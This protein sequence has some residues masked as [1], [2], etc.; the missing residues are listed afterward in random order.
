MKTSA[1]VMAKQ[2]MSNEDWITVSSRVR[3]IFNFGIERSEWFLNCKTAKFIAAIPFLAGCEKAKETAFTHLCIYY[4]S[5]DESGKEI[6]F[7]KES[8]DKDLFSRLLPISNFVG[9]DRN[10]IECCM[11]LLALNMLCNYNKDA[12]YD[13]LIGKYN[14]ISK[15]RWDFEPL[16]TELIKKIETNITDEIS[17]FY[18]IDDAEPGVWKD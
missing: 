8:D 16:Y 15:K 18:S 4:M 2:T 11:S 5:I 7:H 13:E 3:T 1:C 17:E 14:P 12:I 9:G 10:T 6:Y